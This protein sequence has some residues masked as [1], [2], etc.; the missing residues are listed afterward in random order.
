MSKPAA[1]AM[2]LGCMVPAL[3]SQRAAAT[4]PGVLEIPVGHESL[5]SIETAPCYTPTPPTPS[6]R[7][8]VRRSKGARGRSRRRE[9]GA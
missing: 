4:E 3:P 8:A 5:R 2:T 7:S 6:L 1:Q 9:R